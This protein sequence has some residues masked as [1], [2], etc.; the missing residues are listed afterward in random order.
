[1]YPPTTQK[2]H[3]IIHKGSAVILAAVIGAAITSIIAL[4]VARMWN[5]S[6]NVLNTTSLRNQAMQYALNGADTV[7]ATRYDDL[8]GSP[9]AQVGSTRF[10]RSISVEND[11]EATDRKVV[12][13]KVFGNRN[14]DIP[15][16]EMVV[17]KSRV[18]EVLYDTIG[19]NT[20]GAMTQ[21]ASSRLFALVDN[22]FSKDEAYQ[23]FLT[24][25]R[26]DSLLKALEDAVADKYLSKADA[27]TIYR[28]IVDSYSKGETDS[29]LDAL[30]AQVNVNKTNI[31]TNGDNITSVSNRLKTIEDAMSLYLKIQD[32]ADIY[33]TKTV[34][35]STYA[36]QATA[37]THTANTA[38]GSATRP[39]YVDA[40]GNAK[41][42]SGT[43]GSATE[44]IYLKDGVFTKTN[45]GGGGNIKIIKGYIGI[46]HTSSRAN[47]WDPT[48]GRYVKNYKY[49]VAWGGKL[50]VPNGYTREQCTY[51]ITPINFSVY[52]YSTS[53]ATGDIV[54]N[55]TTGVV[56]R[57]N[58]INRRQ[59]VEVAMFVCIAVK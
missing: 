43:V 50:P 36:T 38:V 1:M 51:I 30:K 47:D 39:V 56:S 55:P 28:K 21:E 17:K 29:L 22:V 40:N 45:G 19:T 14:D 52:T 3:K 57:D 16:A 10:Y 49:D 15:L 12:T 48:T 41:A 32:A 44:P 59:M 2:F 42:L 8:Q 23:I 54:F 7:R 24:Q 53:D 20:D 34:A 25:S 13:V 27:D 26:A 46:N 35:A 5:T 6:Y 33:L 11:T 9:L 18:S 37:V 31:A 58:G 4:S